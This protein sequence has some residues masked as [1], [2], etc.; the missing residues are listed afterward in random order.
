MAVSNPKLAARPPGAARRGHPL[1]GQA[2][3]ADGLELVE[4]GVEDGVLEGRAATP[5]GR[6]RAGRHSRAVG[7]QGHRVTSTRTLMRD[8]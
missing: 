6:A 1:H 7:L 8:L 5:Q 3:V 2:D 4:D